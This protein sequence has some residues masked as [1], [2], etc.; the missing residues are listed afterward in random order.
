MHQFCGVA[1]PLKMRLLMPASKGQIAC[2]GV[3]GIFT[4]QQL[5]LLHHCIPGGIV[6]QEPDRKVGRALMPK[7]KYTDCGQGCSSY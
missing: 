4:K 6:S 1:N 2:A 5:G 7:A 3:A